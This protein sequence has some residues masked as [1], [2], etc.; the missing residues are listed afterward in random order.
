MHR[1]TCN[2]LRLDFSLTP[3]SPLSIPARDVTPPR[4]VRAVHPGAGEPSAYIPGSTLKGALR[5]AAEQILRSAAIDCCDREYPCSNRDGVTRARGGAAIYRAAC[6]ACRIFGGKMLRSHLSVTDCFPAEPLNATPA[7]DRAREG[8]PLEV[9]QDDPFYGTLTLRNFERWQVGLLDLILARIN[10]ADIQ[11][12]GN[13]SAGMGCVLM[14]YRRLSFVY[15]GQH[16]QEALQACVHGVGQLIGPNN[17]Y[18]FVYPDTAEMPDLPESAA[19]ESGFG[20]VAVTIADAGSRPENTEEPDDG[21][22]PDESEA[23]PLDEADRVH[24]LIDNVLTQQALAWAS[25]AR[26]HKTR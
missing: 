13:R 22:T 12:G 5:T 16:D 4:F 11:L 26:T 14:R 18:G 6:A 17:P 19:L 7:R 25:Y 23:T 3:L 8:D 15:S 20:F 2:E 24:G 21:E 1:L 10:I 9:V